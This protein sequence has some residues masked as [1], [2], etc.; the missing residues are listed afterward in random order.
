MENRIE[1]LALPKNFPP[2]V[3]AMKGNGSIPQKTLDLLR[4]M[5]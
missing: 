3:V 4:K 5:K 2:T 1:D